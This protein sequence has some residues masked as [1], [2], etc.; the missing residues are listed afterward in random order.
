MRKAKCRPAPYQPRQQLLFRSSPHHQRMITRLILRNQSVFQLGIAVFGA[1][2]GMLLLL[3]SLQ[4]YFDFRDLLTNKTDL[5]NPQFIVIN[6]SVS[7]LNTLSLGNTTFS[8]DEIEELKKLNGISKVGVFTPSL[9]PA[10]AYIEEGAHKNVP[11]LYTDLFFESVPDEFLDVK[12][13]QWKW[14]EGDTNIPVIVPADY[15]NLYNFGFAPGRGMPQISK[16]TI[17]LISFNLLLQTPKGEKKFTGSIAGFSDRINSILVPQSFIDYA[18]REFGN[19]A[20]KDPSRVI[21][22]S[23]DPSSPEL[24]QFLQ[25]KGYETNS[26]SIR[27]SRLNSVLRIIMNI[28]VGIGSVIILMAVLSFIQYSQLLINRSRYEIRTLI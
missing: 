20:V 4:L 23:N 18:N 13:A 27:N 21:I 26:D 10:K 7:M 25:A 16:S 15:L 28:M 1:V 24:A 19:G 14:R 12:T 3:G 9:F 5:I 22:V 8:Q 2:F 17:Q 6:K 11:G